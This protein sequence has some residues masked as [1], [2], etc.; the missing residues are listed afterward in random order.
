MLYNE[1]VNEYILMVTGLEVKKKFKAIKDRYRRELTM[2]QPRSGSSGAEGD[3]TSA[4]PYFSLCGFLNDV[5]PNKNTDDNL[6]SKLLYIVTSFTY[7][8]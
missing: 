7:L 2:P 5:M 3:Q 4:W 1:S 6:G 8:R